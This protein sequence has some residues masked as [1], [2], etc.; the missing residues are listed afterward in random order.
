MSF[1]IK[2]RESTLRKGLD[3]MGPKMGA[4]IL[5]YMATKAT[6]VESMMKAKRPWTDRSGMAKAMLNAKV[7]QPTNTKFRLT[8]AHGVDYGIQLELAHNKN[9]AII[10]PTIR[11][12]GPRLVKDLNNLM[13]KIKL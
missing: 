10:A 12:E 7:S 9:Y 3:N 5:M 4:V 13:S 2:Y 1:T 8:L 11:D 6:K